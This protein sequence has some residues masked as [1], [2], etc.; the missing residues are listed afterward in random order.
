M[1]DRTVR[2]KGGRKGMRSRPAENSPRIDAAD[3]S[4]GGSGRFNDP[5][6]PCTQ[7]TGSDPEGDN[8]VKE[9][10]L[11]AKI[12]KISEAL[13]FID[14]QLEALDCPMKAQT[15]INVAADEILSNIASYAY[16][17]GTGDMTVR[18]EVLESPRTAVITFLDSG[19]PF[20]PLEIQ[21]PDVT[22]P[23]EERSIGGLG[24]FL[25]K[26]TMDNMFYEYREGKNILRIEKQF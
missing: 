24:I 23:A 10:T 18:F 16:A 2:N 5:T 14:A 4:I 8:T 13:D 17:D 11:V 1:A 12:E 20:D 19:M 7:Y 26:K 6:M 9:L 15:Q 3:E 21:D 25:V 22:L